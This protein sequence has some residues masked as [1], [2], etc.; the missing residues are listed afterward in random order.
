M[1]PLLLLFMQERIASQTPYTYTVLPFPELS[2]YMSDMQ[3]KVLRQHGQNRLWLYTCQI[4]RTDISRDGRYGDWPRWVA[5][6]AE[7][8][9][10][11]TWEVIHRSRGDWFTISFTIWTM[12]NIGSSFEEMSRNYAKNI[13]YFHWRKQFLICKNDAANKAYD[14]WEQVILQPLRSKMEGTSQ[15]MALGFPRPISSTTWIKITHVQAP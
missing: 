4:E 11:A 14:F 9:D 13:A 1:S 15:K 8:K 3:R 10:G 5:I 7:Q 6:R 12:N 2:I